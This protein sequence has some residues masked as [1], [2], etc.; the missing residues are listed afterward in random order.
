[1][2]RAEEASLRRPFFR[3]IPG[4]LPSLAFSIHPSSILNLGRK[5]DDED[6]YDDENEMLYR[7]KPW[8]EPCGPT[9]GRRARYI[10]LG[11]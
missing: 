9:L 4:K 10:A 1:M 5:D 7:Y 6:E 2:F 8:D 11:R 3:L